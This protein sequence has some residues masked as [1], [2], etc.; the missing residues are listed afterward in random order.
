MDCLGALIWPYCPILPYCM[1]I[2]VILQ[3][4]GKNHESYKTVK[5]ANLHL[6][7]IINVCMPVLE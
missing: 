2:S 6:S 4:V 1:S 7:P 5:G 3:Y